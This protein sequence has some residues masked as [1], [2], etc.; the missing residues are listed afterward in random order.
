MDIYFKK[1]KIKIPVKEVPLYSTGLMFRTKNTSNLYFN[2]RGKNI[3]LTSWFVFFPFLVLWV[4]ERRKVVDFKVVR[5]FTMV[6]NSQK[7]FHSIVE[8]PLNI[9]NVRIFGFFVGKRKI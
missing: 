8:V 4:D 1:K 6:I 2:L 7:K 9:K 3:S 5:P